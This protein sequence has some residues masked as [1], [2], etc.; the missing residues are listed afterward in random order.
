MKNKV[1]VPSWKNK[2][3]FEKFLTIMGGIL[4]LFVITF[5]FLDLFEVVKYA[6]LISE[7]LLILLFI[8]DILIYK[9]YDKSITKISIVCG[10]LI[11]ACFILNIILKFS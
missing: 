5:C 8:V 4:S 1:K 7:G 6:D 10:L 2:T 3:K 9:D 11:C